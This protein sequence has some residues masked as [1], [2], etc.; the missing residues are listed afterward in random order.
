FL[1]KNKELLPV[2]QDKE[3]KVRST[4]SKAIL[5]RPLSAIISYWQ[6]QI[7]SGGD[8]PPVEKGSDAEVLA[9]VRN[10]PKAVGYVAVGTDLGTG[11]RAVTVQ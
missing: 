10:N 9:F 8:S 2:D 5:G 1:K 4:F 3:A 11:V 7:F 6:Q